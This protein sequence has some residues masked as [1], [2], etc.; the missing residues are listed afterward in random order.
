LSPNL[1]ASWETAV[2]IT[3]ILIAA[4]AA[5]Y[6]AVIVYSGT[7][8][9]RLGVTDSEFWSATGLDRKISGVYLTSLRVLMGILYLETVNENIAKGL[10]GQGFV[11]YV[12]SNLRGNPLP[13]FV[14]FAQ[15]MLLSNWQTVTKLQFLAETL[16]GISLLLGLFT[17]LGGLVG[18]FLQ[19]NIFLLTFGKEWPWIYIIMIVVLALVAVSRSGRTLGLDAFLAKKFPKGLVW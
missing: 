13:W 9:R 14:D 5:F 12:S 3:A 2:A 8:R 4:V 18:V 11:V 15:N 16:V 1:D 6:A 17:V 19:V 7:L 10:Y